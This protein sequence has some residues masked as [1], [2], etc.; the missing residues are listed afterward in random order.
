VKENLIVL[1]DVYLDPNVIRVLMF[2]MQNVVCHKAKHRKILVHFL[3]LATIVRELVT[4]VA[5]IAALRTIQPPKGAASL[6][7]CYGIHLP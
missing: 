4:G 7:K 3:W 2:L 5:C 1:C 6:R